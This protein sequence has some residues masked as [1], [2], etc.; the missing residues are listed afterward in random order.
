MH[1]ARIEKSKRLQ[2]ALAALKAHPRGLTTRQWIQEA[3]ICA[4][5]SVAAEFKAQGIGI[6]CT[7]EGRTPDRA[8]I[9]RYSISERERVA[10]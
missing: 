10:A 1:A 9:Y 8:A 3:D 6:T 2:R 4:C 7:F 5:N